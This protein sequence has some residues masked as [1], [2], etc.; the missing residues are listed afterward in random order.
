LADNGRPLSVHTKAGLL[1][2]LQQS[3]FRTAVFSRNDP[4]RPSL[5]GS[6]IYCLK[7]EPQAIAKYLAPLY[8]FS[9]IRL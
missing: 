5:F 7:W 1:I 8:I 9:V 6:N 3:G 4:G 2:A